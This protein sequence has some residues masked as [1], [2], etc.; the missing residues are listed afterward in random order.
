MKEE[1]EEAKSYPQRHRPAFPTNARMFE[2]AQGMTKREY[3]AIKAMAALI[4]PKTTYAGDIDVLTK[5][6][7]RY[8]DSLIEALNK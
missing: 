7:V 6:A 1:S 4:D 5:Q 3:I 2:A 8:A